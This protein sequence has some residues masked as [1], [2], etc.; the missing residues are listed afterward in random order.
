MFADKSGLLTLHYGKHHVTLVDEIKLWFLDENFTDVVIKVKKSKILLKAHRL[1][2]ASCSPLIRKILDNNITH[3]IDNLTIYFPGIKASSMRHLLNFLYT[4]QTCLKEVE[5]KELRELIKLLDIKTDIWDETPQCAPFLGNTGTQVPFNNNKDYGDSTTSTNDMMGVSDDKIQS[6]SVNLSKD[7]VLSIDQK[8]SDS[9]VLFAEELSIKVD[10]DENS[11]DDDDDGEVDDDEDDAAE[12]SGG[13]L[14]ISPNEEDSRSPESPSNVGTSRKQILTRRSSLNPVNLTVEKNGRRNSI[15]EKNVDQD[16]DYEKVIFPFLSTTRT[17]GAKKYDEENET[18]D[19]FTGVTRI[20]QNIPESYL[21]TP[22][23]K[24]RPGFHNSP[25]QSIPFVP[26]YFSRDFPLQGNVYRSIDGSIDRSPNER[27]KSPNDFHLVKESLENPW[28]S[29]A[30]LRHSYNSG[31]RASFD[32]RS[33]SGGLT[34]VDSSRKDPALLQVNNPNDVQETKARSSSS[35]VQ[36]TNTSK[37]Q[38]LREY[39]CEYCGKQFGMSWNLKTHLRVHTGEKPFACR[40][41]VAMF[42]QKAHLLKHLCS[43]HRNVISEGSGKFNCCFCPVSFENL[44]ELIRH[45]SGPHN[46]LLLS[47]NLHD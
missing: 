16:Q 34:L 14:H 23:R 1:I 27:E 46:N 6:E 41:C 12:R 42:K 43:V 37:I 5:I 22:H 8:K 29:Y 35:P 45:L 13:E 19:E 28:T 39:K 40:L 32:G 31:T 24:R 26:F 11:L 20:P 7:I 3:S 10:V 38:Q 4:G 2:L 17:K 9:I 15:D 25:N 47:K 44:Q 30:A 18:D 36:G 21:V 33:G